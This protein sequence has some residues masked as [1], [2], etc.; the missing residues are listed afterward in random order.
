MSRVK[1]IFYMKSGHLIKVMA[2]EIQTTRDEASGRLMEF[3]LKGASP[4]VVGLMC[5]NIEAVTW[6]RVGS[7]EVPE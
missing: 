1:V 5:E 4:A 2:D 3:T 7:V 6:T